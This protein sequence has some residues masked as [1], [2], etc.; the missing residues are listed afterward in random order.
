MTRSTPDSA[1]MLGVI[2]GPDE[3]DPTTSQEPVPN[4]LAGMKR[5]LRGLRVGLDHKFN[6]QGVDEVTTA[7]L[8]EVVRTVTDLGADMREVRFPEPKDMVTD[9]FPLC[10]TE[11][12]VAHE[13]NYPAR[14]AE[15]GPSLA[16]LIDIGHKVSGL[17]YQKIVLRRN[18]FRGR[19]AALFESIDLLIVPVQSFASP[20][21]AKMATLGENA[22]LVAA[23]LRF[24]CA[25]NMTGSPTITL[26]CGFTDAGTPVAFQFVSAHF[27]EALLCRAGYAYQ[28]ATDWH[29]QHPKL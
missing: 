20:T 21:T 12:A 27:N 3:N 18:D 19:V 2:A 5:G 11:V 7:A 16:G 15:Y 25:F 24:T 23:L 6:T 17:D 10:G 22:E 9:W 1:A 4:Y 14:K 13:A 28:E 29:R 26:P 8:K